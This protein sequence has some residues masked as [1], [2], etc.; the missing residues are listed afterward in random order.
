MSPLMRDLRTLHVKRV[1][2]S[3]T[4]INLNSSFD[5]M[6]CVETVPE[7]VKT[8]MNDEFDCAKTHKDDDA[9]KDRYL[10]N[11]NPTEMLEPHEDALEALTYYPVLQ[12][13]SRNAAG[14]TPIRL[15]Y[16]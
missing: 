12:R 15:K 8:D 13:S 7:T 2:S 3:L 10:E 14:V 4:W 1:A 16:D 11:D 5:D 6:K 9:T